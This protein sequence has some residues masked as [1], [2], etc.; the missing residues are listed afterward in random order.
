MVWDVWSNRASFRVAGTSD[1]AHRFA[2]RLLPVNFDIQWGIQAFLV[3]AM[4][5]APR[6]HI[7]AIRQA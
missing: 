1:F 5:I 6:R 2:G 4:N 3:G 7:M